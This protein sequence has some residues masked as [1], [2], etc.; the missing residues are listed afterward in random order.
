MLVEQR[1]WEDDLDCLDDSQS[2]L[3]TDIFNFAWFL[4]SRGKCPAGCLFCEVVANDI[5]L[6]NWQLFNDHYDMDELT[7]KIHQLHGK[8]KAPLESM[9]F[10]C[11]WCKE[12]L[13]NLRESEGY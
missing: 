3:L 4:H 5:E 10:F 1:V 7:L 13:W 12:E 8:Y 11:E 6:E 9:E 2:L